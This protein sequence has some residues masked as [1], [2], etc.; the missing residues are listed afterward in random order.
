MGQSGSGVEWG[1]VDGMAYHQDMRKAGVRDCVQLKR[2]WDW[3][4]R[5][6]DPLLHFLFHKFC[7]FDWISDCDASIIMKE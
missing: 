3:E 7:I 2:C 5:L 6:C 4:G 1:G